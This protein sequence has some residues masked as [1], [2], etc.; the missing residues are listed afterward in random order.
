MGEDKD[1]IKLFEEKHVRAV[2]DDDAG[3]WWFSVIDIV[4][5]LTEQPDYQKVKNYWKW[6]KNRLTAEGNEM[7]SNTNQLKMMA[8]DGKYYKTDVIDTEQVLRIIQSIPSKKAE[9]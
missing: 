4:G 2:W 6:L 8:A 9:V 1:E 5:I 3:K 7:V